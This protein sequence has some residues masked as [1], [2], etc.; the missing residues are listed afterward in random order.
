MAASLLLAAL[1]LGPPTEG[2][3]PLEC[4]EAADCAK[5]QRC[6]WMESTYINWP[7]LSDPLIEVTTRCVAAE[8]CERPTPKSCWPR[9]AYKVQVDC[10]IEGQDD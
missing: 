8:C 3:V 1:L 2:P 9:Y 7:D 6:A 10:V 5:G 4:Y